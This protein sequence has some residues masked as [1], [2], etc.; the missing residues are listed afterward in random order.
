MQAVTSQIGGIQMIDIDFFEE[1]EIEKEATEQALLSILT[2][3][4]PNT[5]LKTLAKTLSNYFVVI[6]K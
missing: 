6:E 4:K 2:D 1:I 5:N 3:I